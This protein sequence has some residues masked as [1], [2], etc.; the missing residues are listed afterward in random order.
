MTY[1]VYVDVVI[2]TH[3]VYVDICLLLTSQIV[4]LHPYISDHLRQHYVSVHVDVVESSTV[5]IPYVPAP[6]HRVEQEDVVLIHV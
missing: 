3:S 5:L 2:L 4:V 6:V 1:S